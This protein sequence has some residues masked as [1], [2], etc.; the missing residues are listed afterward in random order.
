MPP[1]FESRHRKSTTRLQIPTHAVEEYRVNSALYT[2]EYGAG[3]GGQVDLVSKS[4]TNDFHGEA[5]DYLRNSVFDSR[6]FLDLDNDP[7]APGPT[8]VPPFRMNQFGASFGGPIVKDQTFFFASF[9]GIRQFRG[10]TLHAFVPRA[11]LKSQV[12]QRSPQFAPILDAYPT[13]QLPIDPE[14][15]EFT[16][17]GAIQL[18]ENSGLFRLDHRLS[19][20]TFLSFRL[21]IDDS[22]TTAP[23]GNLLDKQQ[24][25]NRPQNYMISLD[26]IFSPAIFNEA[27]FGIN[28]SP[29][30]NPQVSVFPYAISFANFESLNN[31][32]TDNEVG[33]TWIDN[34]SI[35][36][37][38]NTFKVVGRCFQILR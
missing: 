12:M 16:H 5:F 2:A 22:F 8:K 28:R 18:A 21:A 14:T 32:N 23:L 15:D 17:Q 31:N 9:E 35:V 38:K 27:K 13:G 29:F 26:H 4:G 1:V 34:L 24:I 19:E 36:H 37:G 7:A 30:H 25:V 3:F 11:A 6:S 20:K 10:Q 33:T